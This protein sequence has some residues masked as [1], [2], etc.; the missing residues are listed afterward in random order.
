MIIAKNEYLLTVPEIQTKIELLF[1]KPAS[2]GTVHDILKCD[3]KVRELI[4][5]N[6]DKSNL[7]WRVYQVRDR[8]AIICYHCQRYGHTGENCTAKKNGELPYCF[9]CVDRHMS[10]D[11]SSTERQCINCTR[12]KKEI[13][14]HSVNDHCCPV[15]KSEIDKIRNITDH[16]Y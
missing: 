6:D 11:C 1:S 10:K 15:L 13:V 4:H 16:G 2:G 5:Q 8:Y 9:K 12:C 14:D 3:P 7:E